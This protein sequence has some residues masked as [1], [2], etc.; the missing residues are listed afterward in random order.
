MVRM[1][2]HRVE[3]SDSPLVGGVFLELAE[4]IEFDIYESYADTVLSPQS[5][6]TLQQLLNSD[7]LNPAIQVCLVV[8]FA[9]ELL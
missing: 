8:V 9:I 2:E 4:G 1:L 3:M 5:S 7:R 6:E